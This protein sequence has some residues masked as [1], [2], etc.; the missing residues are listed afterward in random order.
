VEAKFPG[1]KSLDSLD[2]LAIP[3]L[4]K[5]MVLDLARSEFLSRR[6]NLLVPGNSGTG[7]NRDIRSAS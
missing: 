7:K 5:N 6:E 3:T 2:F 4:N 1:V